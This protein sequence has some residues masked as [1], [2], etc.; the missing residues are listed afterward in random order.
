MER[1]YLLGT[2]QKLA[3]WGALQRRRLG[4]LG[5]SQ[6]LEGQF[7]VGER[8]LPK[9]LGAADRNPSLQSHRVL[10]VYI[11]LGVSRAFT[12]PGFLVGQYYLFGFD[13]P[14]LFHCHAYPC[15]SSTNCFV[16]RAT[17]KTVFLNFMFRV[18]VSCFLLSLV[19]LH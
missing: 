11:A 9:C 12:E 3:S 6:F 8:V 14:Y 1:E 5:S 4:V 17:E 10:A 16:S 2:L 19:E 7:L 13:D 18:R 15:L